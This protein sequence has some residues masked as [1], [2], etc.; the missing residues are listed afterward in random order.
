MALFGEKYGDTVRVVTADS[1][2]EFCG[3][4]HIS[5]T[6]QIGLFKIVSESSV[7][8]GVRRVEAVTG[9]GVMALLNEYKDAIIRSAKALKLANVNELPEKC[10]AAAAELK[11]KDKKLESLNQQIANAKTASLFDNAK[12]VGGVKIVSARLDGSAPDALRK[13]GDSV[14]DRNEA[15]IALFA[16][17]VGEKGTFY[18]VCTKEAV[19]KGGNAGTIVREIAALTGGK[20]GG[21][22][23][24]AMA[25]A[26]DISKINE[27]LAQFESVVSNII[28]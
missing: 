1:S 4:T 13:L 5:N 10:A 6:S 3:G 28:K 16:G 23:D 20:G 2:I 8:A 21:K 15:V 27:A 22:P 12:E 19:A 18:C 7:A 9:L 24:G 26:G 11:E 25:G 17:T 14:K